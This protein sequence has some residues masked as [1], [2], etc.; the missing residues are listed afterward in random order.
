MVLLRRV[1]LHVVAVTVLFAM[2][3]TA[4]DPSKMRLKE[5]RKLLQDRGVKCIG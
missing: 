1:V 4:A 5:L 3:S 2:A